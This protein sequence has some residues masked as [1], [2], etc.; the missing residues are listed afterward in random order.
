MSIHETLMREHR[1][2]VDSHNQIVGDVSVADMV[3]IWL[4]VVASA[5]VGIEAQLA[6][7]N[8][9]VGRDEL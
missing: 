8:R 1:K 7:Q 6:F 5:L 9:Q 3:A 4:P 2:A